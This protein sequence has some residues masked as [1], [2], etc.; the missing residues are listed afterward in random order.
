MASSFRT[1][2]GSYQIKPDGIGTLILKDS[3]GNLIHLQLFVM[4]NGNAI[5]MVNV[6]VISPYPEYPDFQIP[7]VVLETT[8]NRMK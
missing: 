8:G 5:Q 6:D 7:L 1:I 2:T 4:D 3:L